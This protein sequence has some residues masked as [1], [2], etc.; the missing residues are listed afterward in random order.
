[1]NYNQNYFQT[2]TSMMKTLYK[3]M[4]KLFWSKRDNFLFLTVKHQ[5]YLIGQDKTLNWSNKKMV[6]KNKGL[7]YNAKKSSRKKQ[8]PTLIRT[9]KYYVKSLP[10]SS[11]IGYI[12]LLPS[13]KFSCLI[14]SFI[15]L[16]SF[17]LEICKKRKHLFEQKNSLRKILKIRV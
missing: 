5:G 4:Y 16:N 11:L 17:G 1:M 6:K 8:C 3:L 12:C 13:K 10:C 15:L 14:T 9:K 7:S 2:F